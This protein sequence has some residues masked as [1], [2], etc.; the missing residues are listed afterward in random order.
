MHRRLPR[1]GL[2][3]AAT[4]L[5]AMVILVLAPAFARAAG[6]P[7]ISL[8]K[9]T[10]TKILYGQDAGVTLKA[11]NPSGQPTGYN[12]SFRDVLPNGVSYVAGSAGSVAGEPQIL[13]NKPTTG[14]TT[15]IWSNVSDLTPASSFS[16]SYQVEHDPNELAVPDTYT[17]DA[18]AYI[19]CNPRFVPDFNGNGQ[20]VQTDPAA[21]CDPDTD[22]SYTGSATASATTE[23]API[24]VSKS[25]PDG[26]ILRGIHDHVGVYTITIEN[27][28]IN[29]SDAVG[30]VDY[31][32]AGVE[33]VGCGGTDIDNTTDAPTNPG[34]DEEYAG[35]GPIDE[36]ALAGCI[37][38]DTV[39]TVS[40]AAGNTEGLPPGV[41]TKLTW[42]D[43]GDMDA[44]DT[45]ELKYL[46]GVP[47]RENTIDWNGAAE[48]NGTEPGT[49]GAQGANLDNNSGPETNE[50]G[51]TAK[52]YENF[53]TGSATYKAPGEDPL[54]V[55]D[56]ASASVTPQ[57]LRIGKSVAPGA[58]TSGT[59]STWTLE[60]DTGEYRYVDD[61]VVTDTLGDG[62]CPLGATNLEG[63]YPPDTPDT[64]SECDAT[65]DLPSAPYTTVEEQTDGTWDITWDQTTDSALARIQP[66]SSHTITFPTRTRNEYQENFTDESPIL[67]NDAGE[68]DVDLVGD[69]FI[70]CAPG[71]DPDNPL[72]PD[73]CDPGDPEKIDADEADGT[74][75]KHSASAGQSAPAPTIDKKV[76][77]TPNADEGAGNDCLTTGTY[78]DSPPPKAAPGD[79]VCFSLRMNF[80]G[81]VDTGSVAV[82]DFIPPGTTYL[83]GSTVATANNTASIGS[84]SPPEPDVDGP[85]L[86][87]PLLTEPDGVVFEVVFAVE[88]QRTPDS[89]D[90]DITDNLMKTVYSN[91]AGTSFPLRDAAAFELEVPELDLLKGVADINDVPGDAG[92]DINDGNPANTDGLFVNGGDVVT[93]RLDVTNNGSIPADNGQVWD[94]LPDE[95]G[96]PS[97]A[98]ISNGGSCND[99]ADGDIANDRIEWSGLPSIA[100]G[101]T[102][103]LTY[104]LT[105]P[106]GYTG[107]DPPNGD[108]FDNEA[109]V[110][111]YEHDGFDGIPFVSIPVDNIDPGQEASANAPAADDPSFVFV[112]APTIDKTRTTEINEAGNNLNT[113]ATIG[114]EITYTVTTT[115]PEGTSLYGADTAIVDAL[116]DRKTLVAGSA[117]AT[118]DFDGPTGVAPVTLPTGAPDP[119]L[120]LSE[121]PANTLRIDFPD[122][123]DNPS[124][125]GDDIIVLTFKATVDDDYPQNRVD[126]TTG[127][128]TLPNTAT[129]SYQNATGN[130]FSES[131]SVNTSIVEPN[132]DIGKAGSNNGG[133]LSPGENVTFTLTASNSGSVAHNNTIVDTIPEGLT[134]V[135]GYEPGPAPPFDPGTPVADGDPV[136][137][138][139]GI[140]DETAR[141][142]TWDEA[143][144]PALASIGAG[145]ANGVDLTYTVLVDNDPVG[146]GTVKNTAGIITTSLPDG[147]DDD[148]ERDSTSASVRYA[149]G[150][151]LESELI[152]ASVVKDSTPTS[153]T[154]GDEITHKLTVSIPA[155]VQHFDMAVVDDV[156]DGLAFGDYVSATCT[157][158][159]TGGGTDIAPS[160]LTPIANGDDT[161]IGWYLG[162]LSSAPTV[163][164]V[165]LIYTTNIGAAY[166]AG[167]DVEDGDE[168][169][170]TA[171]LAFNTTDQIL[172]DPT[173]PPDPGD[174]DQTR[175]TSST[176]DVDEPAIELDKDV[177]GQNADDDT[178][179]TEPGDDYTFTVAVTNTGTSPAYDVVVTDQPDA[180]LT[181][182]VV[183][184]D[185]DWTIDDDWTAGD[186]DIQ[187]TI[188]GPIA[189]DETVTLTYTADL[190]GG[191]S[192]TD[193]QQIVNT[194]DV[195]E[196][197]GVPVATR[198][199]PD[200][201]GVTY[202]Q[203]TEV[204]DDTVTMTVDLPALDLV[205]TTGAAS[206]PDSAPAK[207][208]DPFTWRVVVTNN[209]DATAYD[210]DFADV[211]PPDWDYVADSAVFTPPGSPTGE[212][213]PTTITPAPGGD[214]LAWADV[215]DLAPTESVTL[216][217]DATPAIEAAVTTGTGS[218]NPHVNTASSTFDDGSGSSES[219]DGPYATD[220]D[221]A[222]AVLASPQADLGITKTLTDGNPIAGNLIT[223]SVEVTN[224]GL[225][226]ATGVTVSD[227]LPSNLIFDDVGVVDGPGTCAESGTTAGLVECDFG[228]VA[229]G[230]TRSFDDHRPGRLRPRR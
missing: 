163:R 38:P 150:A 22:P 63:P 168:L 67:A 183:A 181:N 175:E 123:Y 88:V 220:S 55:S 80:P 210:I 54:D 96:C 2:G 134:P 156:P 131:D 42:D 57:D 218:G 106:D 207:V 152:S 129:L 198:T 99:L 77:D 74:Q 29:P 225:E 112:E 182:V 230:A 108:R 76:N 3:V 5:V 148:G 14:K 78:V 157:A 194:A 162:D 205:K 130:D 159:C 136:D 226:D 115:I 195:S 221:T 200:N 66:S 45:I 117:S 187:W 224:N 212:I 101:D 190:V 28:L 82:T 166:G 86:T 160:T 189:P 6:T 149:D 68:N 137:P 114:E 48:G 222:E 51:D 146:A 19:N 64:D 11:S 171:T 122:T 227:Q 15:L 158:G 191:A 164:T 40:L 173:E 75:D 107:G 155:N 102:L 161:R 44:G 43:V 83:A 73:A 8:T 125:S 126:G 120:T 138:D 219:A 133:I 105:I 7:D 84:G 23:L 142:I 196:F 103:T 65:G 143:T 72:A 229:D 56:D 174:F 70:I 92:A 139:G 192:L 16:L 211:L 34:S 209:S 97:V 214:T 4:M 87:W 178:R 184:T 201:V 118:V 203:Y 33:Y 94:L 216:T 26:Q 185:P 180:E 91:T 135:N 144:T 116:G 95:I 49:G 89:G 204:E 153:G 170:N 41:Y 98:D 186:P 128:R 145:A 127:Q 119:V 13:A 176:T 21:D 47:I 215:T 177:S 217:F 179:D 62:Y 147:P 71:D 32:Q 1:W 93:Y 110:R 50:D 17:N 58:F 199:D 151:E 52:T 30:V 36:P 197:W 18:G 79:H 109:G 154:I 59:I 141:T 10:P 223:Y 165:E 27:N 31:L 167:G 60:I 213:E 169:E 81:N 35:S 124:G 9:S 37:A 25:S 12:L 24:K 121:S 228:I 140:W 172:V 202:R 46:A 193:G 85:V 104:D 20:P 208:G 61:L 132:I 113:Q 39:E 53:V 206:F 188:P 69:D 90:G 100:A 111:Q